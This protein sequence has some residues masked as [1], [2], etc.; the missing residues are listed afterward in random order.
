MKRTWMEEELLEHFTLLSDELD[1]VS[2]RG[3]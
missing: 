2:V 3:A 1:A